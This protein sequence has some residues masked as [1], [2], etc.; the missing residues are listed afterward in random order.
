MTVHNLTTP[1]NDGQAAALKVGDTVF[2][3][4]TLFT[5]RDAAHRVML[6]R[7]KIPGLDTRGLALYHCGPLAKMADGRW[8]ILSAGPTTSHRME[9]LEAKVIERFGVSLVIGKGGMGAQTLDAL[10]RCGAAYLSFPSSAALAAKM[11]GDVKAVH[12]LDELGMAEAV[13]VLEASSFGPLVVSMDS[14]GRSL[15]RNVE[16][17]SKANLNRILRE[18]G[19]C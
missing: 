10:K 12:F 14:R 7:G 15:Y 5:A 2:L 13:W 19:L 18:R 4:G 1:L 3:S 17:A 6:E 16:K 9:P 8:R 11:L